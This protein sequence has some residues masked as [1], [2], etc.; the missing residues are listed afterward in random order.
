MSRVFHVTVGDRRRSPQTAPPPA[1]VPAAGPAPGG[2]ERQ[3]GIVAGYLA[4][5][6]P[7]LIYAENPPQNEPR[8][9]GGW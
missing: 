3:P 9:R 6:P 8:S 2:E 7:H 5:H 1:A 4:P